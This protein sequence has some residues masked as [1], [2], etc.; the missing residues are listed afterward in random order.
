MK[1]TKTKIAMVNFA[2]NAEKL[3]EVDVLYVKNKIKR[4]VKEAAIESVLESQ[5]HS[6]ADML[7]ADGYI[8]GDYIFKDGKTIPVA[9]SQEQLQEMVD[10][11]K[12][13]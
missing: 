12:G 13:I 11:I 4:A 6:Y 1:R 8:P 9:Q 2:N 10:R 3:A 7:I 5:R